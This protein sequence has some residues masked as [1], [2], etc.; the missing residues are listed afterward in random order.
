MQ[1][2]TRALV[3]AAAL[4][5]GALGRADPGEIASVINA[6]DLFKLKQVRDPAVSPDG[7][8]IA[9]EV[10]DIA[11]V[12]A[13]DRLYE[14]NLWL[15]PARG[16]SEAVALTRGEY[17]GE[18][19]A[20]SPDGERLA[21][22]RQ[23]N[24]RPQVF[25]I[26]VSKPAELLQITSLGTGAVHPRWSPDGALIAFTSY[27]SW[28][29]ER[30]ADPEETPPWPGERPMRG[31]NDVAAPASPPV[32]AAAD[33]SWAALRSFLDAN[34]H[35]GLARSTSRLNFAGEGEFEGQPSFA[36]CYITEARPGSTARS[37]TP[38]YGSYADPQW[39]PGA[40][41]IVCCG[42]ADPAANP[43]RSPGRDLWVVGLD[44]IRRERIHIDGFD[45]SEPRVS[46]A[47]NAV[48]FLAQSR[49]DP[50][51]GQAIVGAQ[52]LSL[53]TPAR[54]LTE[55]LDRSAVDLA[56]SRDG[57]T[58]YFTAQSNGGRPLYRVSPGGAAPAERLSAFEGTTGPFDIGPDI[59]AL[60]RSK[61]ANPSELFAADLD[62]K[63]L[64]ILT[65]HNS[66]WL[67]QKLISTP[68]RHTLTRPDGT[69]LDL[70]LVK[71][72]NTDS[73]VKAP[74]VVEVHG[75]PQLMWGAGEPANWFEFQY[76]AARG[77]GV[78]YS[79]PRGSLGYGRRFQAGSSK[80]WGP[81]PASDVLA[82]ADFAAQQP[83]ADRSRQSI[84]GG[85]YGASLAAWILTHDHRFKAAVLRSGVYDLSLFV[86]EGR[87]WSQVHDAFGGYPWDPQTRAL[88]DANSP[89]TFVAQCTTPALFMQG[90]RDGRVGLAQGQLFYRALKALGRPAEYVLYPGGLHEMVQ[91]GN[92]LQRLDEIVRADEFMRR[93]TADQ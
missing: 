18:Q 21:F 53:R 43:D 32:L 5:A 28:D 52:S 65:A 70:W 71:P 61:A 73:A 47:G 93:Y 15:A 25:V 76:L 8:R 1:S 42:P 54:L 69:K 68:E 50:L 22:V 59:I 24:G 9:Y 17:G 49:K 4:Y 56:W 55:S 26:A 82:A 75:G 7:S 60:V 33:G 58:L 62:G 35:L 87:A 77:Y 2:L 83:W 31:A 45:L 66:P 74:L 38:G 46:A 34:E 10:T 29:D 19:P 30:A 6:T 13:G 27:L 39:L 80:D 44:G 36:H 92:P 72:V 78:V 90:D 3:L 51:Y 40:N 79:N 81:G 48:A 37:L 88:L 84:I 91:T 12:P 14:T 57:R 16:G 63:E 85:S 86:G 89:L 11:L 41:G 64:R 67:G 20:W 23:V